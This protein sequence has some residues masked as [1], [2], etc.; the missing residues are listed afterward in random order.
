MEGPAKRLEQDYEHR[1]RTKDIVQ[2]SEYL[3]PSGT[4]NDDETDSPSSK[5]GAKTDIRIIGRKYLEIKGK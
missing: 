3:C 1:S 5:C 2:R 4:N